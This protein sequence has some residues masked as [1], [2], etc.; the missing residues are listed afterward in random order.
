M[1]QVLWKQC[2]M[3][4]WMKAHHQSTMT[5]FSS[6]EI[7]L[8]TTPEPMTTTTTH[9]RIV[10]YNWKLHAAD[11]DFLQ[12]LTI[13][14]WLSVYFSWSIFICLWKM[15]IWQP[16]E[17]YE[18]IEKHYRLGITIKIISFV[19]KRKEI[20]NVKVYSQQ[21]ASASKNLAIE[22][23]LN[24]TSLAALYSSIQILFVSRK[25]T[26]I[27]FRRR[28]SQSYEN[29]WFD[30]KKDMA[31]EKQKNETKWTQA[32]RKRWEMRYR[33]DRNVPVAGENAHVRKQFPQIS[34]ITFY[35]VLIV[36]AT[37]FMY[38]CADVT[39]AHDLYVWVNTVCEWVC[40]LLAIVSTFDFSLFSKNKYYTTHNLTF[41]LIHSRLHFYTYREERHKFSISFTLENQLLSVI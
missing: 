7:Q 24:G 39:R 12:R 16:A 32:N 5:Q 26:G 11:Y 23:T 14:V 15:K 19:W 10:Y 27:H 4:L 33:M 20:V 37:K 8:M 13:V 17:I 22:M 25:S 9:E 28:F 18:V 3:I 29:D 31:E 40:Y 21:N 34:N 38:V 36:C 2:E 41:A 30:E 1:Q 6:I 35:R